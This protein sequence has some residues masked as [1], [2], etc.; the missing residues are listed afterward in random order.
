[1]PNIRELVGLRQ[2]LGELE[3]K[4]KTIPDYERGAVKCEIDKLKRDIAHL[5][6]ILST[7]PKARHDA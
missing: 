2:L 3:R 7:P 1:M 4:S 6:A 5:E